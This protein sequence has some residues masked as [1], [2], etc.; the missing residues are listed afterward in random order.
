MNEWKGTSTAGSSLAA[1]PSQLQLRRDLPEYSVCGKAEP[2]AVLLKPKAQGNEGL[3]IAA[4]PSYKHHNVQPRHR[5]PRS[6]WR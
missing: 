3:H 2:V 1:R 6:L 5:A 4:C